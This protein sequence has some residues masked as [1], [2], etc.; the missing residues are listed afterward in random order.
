MDKKD[1]RF[2]NVI[3][4]GKN[5]N[6]TVHD[7]TDINNAID[8]AI[9]FILKKFN[10]PDS[11]FSTQKSYFQTNLSKGI[12]N[13]KKIPKPTQLTLNFNETWEDLYTGLFNESPSIN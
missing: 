5:L 8:K 1:Y 13:I 6:F 9:K 11:E 10:I 4:K 3:V 7:A 12:I 2:E